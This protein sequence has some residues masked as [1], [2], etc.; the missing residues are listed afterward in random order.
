MTASV[1]RSTNAA[2]PLPLVRPWAMNRPSADERVQY[3]DRYPLVR[4][5]RDVVPGSVSQPAPYGVVLAL[6]YPVRHSLGLAAPS[7][8]CINSRFSALV[9]RQP[10]VRMLSI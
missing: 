8:P 7:Q 6:G 3:D 9:A 5:T 10:V 4:S 2:L 1:S